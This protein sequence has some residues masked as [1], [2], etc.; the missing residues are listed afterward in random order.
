MPMPHYYTLLVQS[1]FC[2]LIC[3]LKKG[4]TLF[5]FVTIFFLYLYDSVL[6]YFDHKNLLLVVDS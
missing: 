1:I 3:T 4:L 5:Y 6:V 2:I